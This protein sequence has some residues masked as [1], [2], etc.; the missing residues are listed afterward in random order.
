MAALG[1]AGVVYGLTEG[2]SR[3]WNTASIISVVLGLLLLI[4]FVVNEATV[5]DPMLP[6]SLFRNRTFSASNVT[7]FILY[8][9]LAGSLFLIPV[10]LQIVSGYS[11]LEAGVSLLPVTILLLLLSSRVGRLAT[12]YGPRWFM[13]FGPVI[14][15]VGLV[16]LSR[17]GQNTN[18]VTDVLP[19]VLVFGL[20]MA[21]TVA[22]LTATVLAAAPQHMVGV[23][24]AVNNDIA[25]T[26]GLI[27]VAVLPGLA[28]ITA[29]AY[30]DPAA[31]SAGFSRA[32]IIAGIAAAAA[33]VVSAVYV[34]NDVMAVDAE[35][36]DQ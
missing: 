19:A 2:P 36:V 35:P 21:L 3:H 6:L 26:A 31:L 32:V 5:R 29:A 24:S 23:A 34:R 16:L 15:G 33:G 25:R 17:V 4:G 11:P 13:T 18:Y 8:G 22:P 12:R 9:A 10:Q 1:L 27:A 14:A 20:G 7:T 30:G 28:G